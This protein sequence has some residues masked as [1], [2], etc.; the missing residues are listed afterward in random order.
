MQYRLYFPVVVCSLLVVMAAGPGRGEDL[1]MYKSCLL[2]CYR[3]VKTYGKVVFNGKLCAENCVL[4]NGASIDGKC[5]PPSKRGDFEL[6]L[7]AECRNLCERRCAPDFHHD[8]MDAHACIFMCIKSH[9][10]MIAC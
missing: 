7:T 2:E 9:K 10:K 6:L 5:Y 8:S 3:C 4:T 1:R